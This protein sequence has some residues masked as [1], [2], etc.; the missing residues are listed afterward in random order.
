MLVTGL[1][2]GSRYPA[3]TTGGGIPTF[4]PVDL[5]V[6]ANV[7]MAHLGLDGTPVR[8]FVATNAMYLGNLPLARAPYYLAFKQGMADLLRGLLG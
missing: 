4:V 1:P 3:G 5:A 2:D 6:R 7:W 8:D